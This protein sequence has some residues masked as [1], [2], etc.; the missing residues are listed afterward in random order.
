MIEATV[1][2]GRVAGIRIAAHWSALVTIALFAWIL[3]AS[4]SGTGSAVMVWST[5]ILGAVALVVCLLAHEL[6][7]S[8]VARRNGVQV[9]EIVLWLLGGVSELTDEPGDARADLKIA[10][11]GPATSV[12]LGGVAG[13]AAALS[14][15]VSPDG[16][17]TAALL[18]LATVNIILA[19]FNMLP[20]APLDGGRVLRAA[21]WWR[22]G[23]RLRAA[24]T[25]ARSGQVLGTVLMLLGVA[26]VILFGQFGGLWLVLLGWFLRTA[27]RTELVL[28]GLR[29]RLG[30][31]TIGDVMTPSP[32]AFPAG[33]TI[34]EALRSEAPRTQHR[35]FPVVDA[36]N[37][38][39]G[40]V[41]WS[42]L[43]A[44][45]E[46]ARATTRL[47]D[48]TRKLVPAA[49]ANA[50]EPLADLATRVVL[51]PN[52]DAVAVVN[53][54]GH[55]IGLVTATDLALACDRSALGLPIT[56]APR[57]LR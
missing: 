11:A 55:L 51:R 10:V 30:G 45:P 42:D 47:A 41:A 27:A 34:A 26:E 24:A 40:V 25:A 20:G 35:V 18:W 19:L 1:P 22:S 8:I 28:S 29:H 2:L 56:P 12:L 23:D 21:L 38:P 9:Q 33:W 16:P 4:L 52:L 46:P 44:V 37:H 6:A 15:L 53:I 13:I 31:T 36:A 49:I 5:A 32:M 43:A 3:G 7:H 50:D 54:A 57:S 17:V 39:V 14:A 48:V